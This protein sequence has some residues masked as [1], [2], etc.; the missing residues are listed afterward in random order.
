MKALKQYQE[1]RLQM[2]RI[3][4]VSK[5][6]NK[7]RNKQSHDFAW[8]WRLWLSDEIQFQGLLE[9]S[10]YS[11]QR[12]ASCCYSSCVLRLYVFPHKCLELFLEAVWEGH[13]TVQ[14]RDAAGRITARPHQCNVE[15]PA[16]T[17]LC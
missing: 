2:F 5:R 11:K 10:F 16:P 1:F 17:V 12:D 3:Y 9:C 7:Y 4:Y 15:P 8:P 6:G 14:E 13:S